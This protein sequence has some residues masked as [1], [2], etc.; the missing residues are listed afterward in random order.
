MKKIALLLFTLVLSINLIA[1]TEIDF[2]SGTVNDYFDFDSNNFSVI[3]RSNFDTYLNPSA[4]ISEI[5]Y[6]NPATGNDAI[7][8]KINPVDQSDNGV[9]TFQINIASP[10]ISPATVWLY[11]DVIGTSSRI[12]MNNIT[13]NA[14]NE[15]FTANIGV[16][17]M[18]QI[19]TQ[20][21]NYNRLKI[22]LQQGT[23]QG[24]LLFALDNVIVQPHLT[25]SNPYFE[26]SIFKY[27]PNPVNDILQFQSKSIIEKL[28]VLNITGQGVLSAN[29]N[30]REGQLDL[31][32]LNIGLYF[33]EVTTN[34][35]T[36]IFKIVKN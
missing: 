30:S 1:Q 19:G 24:T 29:I 33:L 18:V 13:L 11:N 32:S 7:T 21:T 26:A 12:E 14:W 8:L 34:N 20:Y 35:R 16:A 17:D 10:N 2:E 6:L 27:F 15:W 31:S 36:E 5:R 3:L 28:K 22:F 4:N 23:D 25:L 9:I